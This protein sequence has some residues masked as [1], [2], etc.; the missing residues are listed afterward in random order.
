MILMRFLRGIASV[1][2]KQTRMEHL[3]NDTDRAN[4]EVLREKL[5]PVP[6]FSTINPMDWPGID[7]G[8]TL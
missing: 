5:V 1:V 4:T 3:W 7:P 2:D 6:L 8:P